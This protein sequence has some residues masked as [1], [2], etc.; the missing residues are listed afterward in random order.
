[1]TLE[2]NRW[3]RA[4]VVLLVLIAGL[5]L[6][7]LL[8]DIGQRFGD[9]IVMFFLAW[10]LAFV[11]SPLTHSIERATRVP[12]ALAAAGVYLVLFVGLLTG[13]ILIVPA[14]LVQLAELGKVLPAYAEQVPRLLGEIQSDLNAR[15]VDVDITSLYQPRDLSQSI[16][17]LGSAA[18]QNLVSILTGVF[19]VV[20]MV[21]LVFVLSFYM[22]V[23]GDLIESTLL[24]FVPDSRRVEVDFFLDSVNRTFGGF[25]RGTLIQAVIYA[26]G[27]ALVMIVAGLDFVLVAS[28]FAGIIMVV[29]IFGPFVATIPPVLIALTSAPVSTVLIVVGGLLVLQQVTFNMIA[30][31][32]MSDSLGMHPL[33]IFAALLIGGRVAGFAGAIFGV[34]VAAVLWAMF[35]QALESTRYGRMAMERQIAAEDERARRIAAGELSPG[36]LAWLRQQLGRT[37]TPAEAEEREPVRR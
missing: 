6:G 20:F 15:H 1:M 10:L 3:F 11:L 5:Y 13:L 7:G 35:R 12:R 23:D 16:A 17:G 2:Q 14:L 31:K 22:V 32:V 4:L 36:A 19:N 29:P 21:V 25:L 33:L 24:S 9:I 34:P 30:P 8:W 28:V 37:R 18:V 26:C 27:T